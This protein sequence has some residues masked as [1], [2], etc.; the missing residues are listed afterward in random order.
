M[1]YKKPKES[2]EIK[3]PM[4]LM[5]Q[6]KPKNPYK[7]EKRLKTESEEEEMLGYCYR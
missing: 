4:E 3:K 1:N 2:K 7:L 6:L 5:V